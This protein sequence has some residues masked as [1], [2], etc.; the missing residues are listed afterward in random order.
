[1]NAEVG[2]LLMAYGSPASLED[3]EAYYTHIRGGRTPPPDAIEGLRDRYRR[4]GGRSPLPDI[5]QRQAVELEAALRGQGISA[6]A[7]VGM[8]HAPPFISDTVAQM[9]G[10]GIKKAAG[11]ALA[12]HYSKMSIGGYISAAA[13]A[14]LEHH[15]EMRFVEHYHDHPGLIRA[16]A[17]RVEDARRSLAPG[18]HVPV[19]FTAHSLPQRIL[20]WADPYPR[21][22][23]ETCAL[24]AS[25]SRVE[26][27]QFAFQSASHTGEPWLGPDILDVLEELRAR[28]EREVIVS[29]IGFVADHLEVLYDI[30]VEAQRIADRL[31]LRLIRAPSLNDGPDFVAV[32]AD[33]AGAM[34][35][36]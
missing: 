19:I 7:Y 9:A 3:V 32:L 13:S 10:D 1:M 21:Q 28:G 2:V 11:V 6:R 27:W 12:P 18:R 24:V 22:L 30:D 29:P 14:A 25:A 26:I 31:G 36:A 34:L 23:H 20:Q 16:L 33:V 5:T 15:V 35:A 4:I 8:K 17:R